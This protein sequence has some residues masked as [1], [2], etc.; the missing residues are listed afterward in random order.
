MGSRRFRV[1]AEGDFILWV[2]D[3]VIDVVDDEW[4]RTFFNLETPSQIVRHLALNL[5]VHARPLNALD[6]WADQP[7]G[8]A[9]VVMYDPLLTQD[10]EFEVEELGRTGAHESLRGETR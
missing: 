3:S 6:G 8:N 7:P 10:W 5:F 2:H 1:H 4:R 9:H